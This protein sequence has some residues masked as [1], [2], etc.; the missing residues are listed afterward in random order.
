M[1]DQNDDVTM[2]FYFVFWQIGIVC[3]YLWDAPDLHGYYTRPD[4]V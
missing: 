1:F 2:I 3:M 4:D